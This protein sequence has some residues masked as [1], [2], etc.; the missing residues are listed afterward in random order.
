MSG[1]NPLGRQRAAHPGP[2]LAALVAAFLALMVLAQPAMAAALPELTGRV[3]D[4]AHLL[5]A[6]TATAIEQKLAAY[7][8]KSSDQV[9]VATIDSLGGEA[10]EP[11][12]NRLF[13]AWGL[14]QK[15]ENN[16]LLLLVAKNDRK[17]RIEV[18]YGLEGVMTDA[19]SKLII[20]DTIIPAFRRGDFAGGIS[21]GVD[22]IL[23]V[24]SGDVADL[25]A[26]AA[27]NQQTASSQPD[28]FGYVFFFIWFVIF[29]GGFGLAVLPR[30]F[31]QKIAPGRYRWLGHDFM[32]QNRPRGGGWYYGGGGGSSGGGFSGGGGSSGGGGASGG[33]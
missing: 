8:A 4:D 27:R 7:E 20:E 17:V 32:V 28:W 18:G 6:A 15:Q 26:R 25:Q 10:I 19:A 9:V 23:S 31:G 24:L 2:M 12:A 30:I 11:Y 16:G 5:D 13:R 29:F 21:K 22:D 3:V 1:A 33:W 14:G